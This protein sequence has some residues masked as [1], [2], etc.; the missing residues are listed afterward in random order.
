M[1]RLMS[2]SCPGSSIVTKSKEEDGAEEE[3]DAIIECL[4]RDGGKING[5]DRQKDTPYFPRRSST[6]PS[7]TN[8]LQPS[9]PQTRP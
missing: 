4:S 1:M 6:S 9:P 8:L 3:E 5:T 2:V 7:Q